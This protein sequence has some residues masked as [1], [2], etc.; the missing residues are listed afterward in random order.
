MR[1]T[2]ILIPAFAG[3]TLVSSLDTRQTGGGNGPYGPGVCQPRK[4]TR[5]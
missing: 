4:Y 2:A 3:V 5:P 1:F